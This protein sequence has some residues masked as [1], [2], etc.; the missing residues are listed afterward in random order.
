MRFVH[1][2]ICTT[3]LALLVACGGSTTMAAPTPPALTASVAATEAIAFTPNSVT[4]QKGGTITFVFGQIAHNVYFA[5]AQTG[6]PGNITGVNA[7]VSKPLTF[8]STGTF[9]YN[10]HIHPGMQ[11]TVIVAGSAP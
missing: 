6:A 1:R 10:C 4:I 5:N 7:N 11:G 8:N 9:I 2:S 3:P